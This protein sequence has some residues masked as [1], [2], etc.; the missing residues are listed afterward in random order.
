MMIIKYLTE[1][2]TIAQLREW[3]GDRPTA[4]QAESERIFRAACREFTL[5][6]VQ[7]QKELL[8]LGKLEEYLTDGRGF[9][10]YVRCPSEVKRAVKA[11]T[12]GFPSFFG[13][14][15]ELYSSEAARGNI[16]ILFGMMLDELDKGN[17]WGVF[18]DL[19]ANQPKVQPK[20]EQQPAA[21]QPVNQQNYNGYNSF[22]SY[23]QP[24]IRH[25]RFG[26]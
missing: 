11:G 13:K 26:A 17:D 18:I 7:S 14:S 4:K 9:Y 21:A 20:K 25:F 12:M 3:N 10:L 19:L 23:Q 24:T 16:M 1:E 2:Q 5:V 8:R 15:E 22:G 6:E